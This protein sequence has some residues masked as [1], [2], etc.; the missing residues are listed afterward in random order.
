MGCKCHAKA[1]SRARERSCAVMCHVCPERRGDACTAQE[2]PCAEIVRLRLD[3][4]LNHHPDGAGVLVWL[5][6]RWYG[7]PMP[8]RAAWPV[9]RRLYRWP[10]LSGPLPWCGCVKRLKDRWGTTIGN[11]R[12]RK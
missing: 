9:L 12:T 3:C 10:Q 7:V 11:A 4:P 1:D 2:M 6:V 8:I 5:G